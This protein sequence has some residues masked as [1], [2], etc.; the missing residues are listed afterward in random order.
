MKYLFSDWDNIKKNL[1]NKMLFVFLDYDGTLSA[2]RNYPHLAGLS[3]KN[4]LLLR[5]LKENPHCRLAIISG[6]SL[7]N[8]KKIVGLKKIIY[9]GNHGLEI[10]G[11][12]AKLES[13]VMPRLKLIMRY[14]A[15]EMREVLSGFKGV[16]VEDKGLTLSL[17][18]RMS[19]KNNIPKIKTLFKRIIHPY[20]VRKKIKFNMGKKVY[21]IKPMMKW[22]KGSAVNWILAMQDYGAIQADI[23]PIYIGDDATD[24]DAF[25]AL[26]G[27]G[28]TVFVGNKKKSKARYYLKNTNEVTDFLARMLDLIKQ[29]NYG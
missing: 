6:R 24:E 7:E 26:R 13:Q 17:H 8:I 11:P 10:H 19:S 4:K 28:I 27:R 5:K 25:A 20:I 9:A 3:L 12:K 15:E 2:I 29:S 18:Y 21:E 14:I 16:L 23:M 22:D 1:L